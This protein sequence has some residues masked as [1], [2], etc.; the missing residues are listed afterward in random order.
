M[1]DLKA[2]ADIHGSCASDFSGV[3]DAFERNFALRNEVGAAVA[4]LTG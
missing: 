3:R 4:A 2:D 1:S